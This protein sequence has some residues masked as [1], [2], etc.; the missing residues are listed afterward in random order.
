MSRIGLRPIVI[1]ENVGIELRQS[2]SVVVVSCDSVEQSYSLPDFLVFKLENRELFVLPRVN[3]SDKVKK[4]WGLHCK[5]CSNMI[6][7]L[8]DK[9]VLIL[10]LNGV[11]YRA[12]FDQQERLL[13]LSLGYSHDICVLIPKDILINCPKVDVIEISGSDKQKVGMVA[14]RIKKLRKTEPYKG[15]GIKLAGEFVLRKAG[16][17]K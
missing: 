3:I 1:K 6:T 12:I 2:D 8:T 13:I 16:K 15:K 7:G 5:L 4:M 11:G 17:R 9:F 10:E 14:A